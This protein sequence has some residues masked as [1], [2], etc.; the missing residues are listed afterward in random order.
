MILKHLDK[1]EDRIELGTTHDNLGFAL[2]GGGDLAGARDH[3]KEA[4]RV[5][6]EIYGK[7]THPQSGI[8]Y[9]GL[10]G[11]LRAQGDLDGAKE[12][13]TKGIIAFAFSSKTRDKLNI[14]LNMNN[15]GLVMW[16][17]QDFRSA[18]H[19]FA[20]ALH[21]GVDEKEHPLELAVVY[22]NYAN[23]L[24]EQREFTFAPYYFSKSL[25][26]YR[27]AHKTENHEDIMAAYTNLADAWCAQGKFEKGKL[28]YQRAQAVSKQLFKDQGDEFFAERIEK[29]NE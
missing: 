29:C 2:W 6:I 21:R 5:K 19:H 12:A 24:K 13:Y 15:L 22:K 4:I 1:R 28:F 9:S 14:V 26:L 25:E 7:E 10:G 3:F 27:A 11:V 18:Q 23:S 16:D 17:K 8:S 20:S